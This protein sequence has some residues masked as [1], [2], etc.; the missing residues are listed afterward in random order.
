MREILKMIKSAMILKMAKTKSMDARFSIRFVG[1][2]W[3]G[4]SLV[5]APG[6]SAKETEAKA[7]LLSSI[8]NFQALPLEKNENWIE[9]AYDKIP[10]SHVEFHGGE[11]HFHI[12]KSNSVVAYKLPSPLKLRKIKFVIEIQGDL[13][14]PAL[15]S[16]PEKDQDWEE[17]YMFRVGLVATGKNTLGFFGE[18]FAPVWVRQLYS[19]VPK[20]LGLDKVYFYNVGR[21]PME[22]GMSRIHP[23]S[24]G[25][26]HEEIVALRGVPTAAVRS[27]GGKD[28]PNPNLMSIEKDV[29]PNREIAAFWFSIDGDQTHS[30][31]HVTLKSFEFLVGQK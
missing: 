2:V 24:R 21:P 14:T 18:R 23:E 1:F 3:A 5:L 12:L 28:A 22:V 31:Y 26:F 13:A 10:S 9:V 15:K 16:K 11:V 25:Q 20:N 4:V 8:E 17:D 29:D 30:T 27:S 19:L 7:S 6:A